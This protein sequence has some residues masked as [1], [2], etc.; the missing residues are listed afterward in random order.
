[1]AAQQMNM[2]VIANNLANANTTGYKRSRGNF[3]DMIY[4]NI[5]PAGAETANNTK[6]P[7]GVQ[8]G[9]GTK[10][11]SV[12]KIFTQGNFTETGNNLDLAIE[13]KGFFKV[14][15]GSQ[16]TYTRSG[17]FKVDSE[18]YVTDA[19]GSRLQPEISIPKGTVSMHVEPGGTFTA[20][21]ASGTVLTTVKLRLYDFP[22]P[23]GLQSIGKNLF[24]TSQASG[25]VIEAQPGTEGL[26][27]LLQGY[28]EA[29]NINV[30]EEMVNMI[31]SQRAY[32]ANS[33]VI[34]A[35]DEMLKEANTVKG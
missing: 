25:E 2:D 11:V 10:T 28:L 24:V 31:L 14:L 13:G 1:M 7:T 21:D 22:N 3:E 5:V 15:R 9:L 33:K 34:K 27:Q 6:I 8:L 35:A 4:Q 30:V 12:E 29:S 20:M 17:S 32:E 23:A 16:E 18:G 26:G 19:T